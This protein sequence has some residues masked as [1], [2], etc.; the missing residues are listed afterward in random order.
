[1]KIGKMKVKLNEIMFQMSSFDRAT[2]FANI[3]W[4]G[5]SEMPVSLQLCL[6]PLSGLE[7]WQI[8]DCQLFSLEDPALRPESHRLAR[9]AKQLQV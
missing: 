4:T 1:M 3:P 5:A 2:V 8:P 7:K 6:D 9:I